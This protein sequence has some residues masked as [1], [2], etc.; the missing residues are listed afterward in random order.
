MYSEH[1]MEMQIAAITVNKFIVLIGEL[2][3][4]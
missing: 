3:M 2:I 1:A 4:K